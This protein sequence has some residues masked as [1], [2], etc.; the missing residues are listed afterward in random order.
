KEIHFREDCLG[1]ELGL[2]YLQTKDGNEIDFLVTRETL[3]CLMLEV[4]W[5]DSQRSKNFL[6]FDRHLGK[7]PKVQIVKKLDRETTYPDGTEIRQAHTW[8]EKILL[9]GG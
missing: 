1:E 8:L 6:L 4:K 9:P 5:A 3:P 7:V 2:H